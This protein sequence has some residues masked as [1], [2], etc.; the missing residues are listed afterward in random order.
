MDMFNPL[1]VKKYEEILKANPQSKVFCSLAQ[2]YRMEKNLKKAEKICLQGISHNPSYSAGY[3][4][5][6]KIH[7]DSNK[8]D[9]ALAILNQAK[10]LG[11]ENHQVYQLLGEIY[12]EKREPLKTLSAFKMV[13]FLKPWDQTA[14]KTVEHL[15]TMLLVE[16]AVEKTEEAAAPKSARETKQKAR[17][18]DFLDLKK[19]KKR[20]KM[21]RLQKILSRLERRSSPPPE[22]T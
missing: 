3:V 10:E 11:P 19:G 5:L 21:Q 20:K 22:Q 16:K 9:R 17:A 1:L 15:E 12:R 6:A 13:L 14:K 2:V 18:P 4:L 7:R 8:I